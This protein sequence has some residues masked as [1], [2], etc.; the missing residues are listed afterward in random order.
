[1]INYDWVIKL[2]LNC[3]LIGLPMVG[4]TTIFNLLTGSG[5]KT[6]NFLTGRT[7][8]N[9]GAARLPDERVDYLS[10]LY[11]PR[12]TT[13][14][15]IQFSDVPGLVRGSSQGKGVGNQFL[16]AIRNV[17]ML[18][19]VVRSFINRDV[20]HVDDTINPLRDIET[21][22]MELLFADMGVIEKRIERL[23]SGKK[24]KKENLL[25]L[26]VL[27]K[28]LS[29]LENEVSI[30]RLDLLPEEKLVLKNYSFLTEK[31]L[32]LVIN[33]DEEQFNAKHYPGREELKAYA[34]ERGI[35]VLEISGKIEMEI[36]QLPA[37]DRELFLSDLGITQSGIDRLARAAYDYLGLISFFTVGDDEVKAWTILKGT[38][39]RKAAGK[40]HSDI[41]RGF[42]KA[43]VVK[44]DD[45][46]QMESM[47]RVKEKGMFRLEGK[48]YLVAD[49][50]VINFRFN[51]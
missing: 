33:T 51:V 16:N 30:G 36:C 37:E 6:S 32:I 31:P 38:E 21:I 48:E 27:E 35:P 22:N 20:P 11:Q 45:L 40:I 9:V 8:T 39:A 7:E 3:G 44:Y 5:A 49:G 42:I 4:K 34:M 47:T 12:K 24:V 17:D 46:K 18:A 2:N 14:A 41:E 10:G 29:A 23:K 43:E 28:C 13:Y 1:M 15:Q 25:E 50:D 19:H 26:E